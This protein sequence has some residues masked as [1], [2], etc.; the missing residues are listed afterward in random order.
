[1]SIQSPSSWPSLI[2]LSRQ[3]KSCAP[4]STHSLFTSTDIM[5]NKV[6]R[7]DGGLSAQPHLQIVFSS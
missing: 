4:A 7:E 2:Q 1:M 3:H 6:R 5:Q